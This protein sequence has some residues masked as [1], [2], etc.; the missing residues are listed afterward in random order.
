[1]QVPLSHCIFD[2]SRCLAGHWTSL[3]EQLDTGQAPHATCRRQEPRRQKQQ[4]RRQQRRQK[5]QRR[6]QRPLARPVGD[7]RPRVT[8]TASLQPPWPRPAAADTQQRPPRAD[9]S[10]CRRHRQPARSAAAA[11]LLTGPRRVHCRHLRCCRKGFGGGG[12]GGDRAGQVGRV[13]IAGGNQRAT[14]S[15]RPYDTSREGRLSTSQ[16]PRLVIGRVSKREN[17]K[18]GGTRPHLVSRTL[19]LALIDRTTTV[20]Y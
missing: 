18:R 15:A 13:V 11:R 16:P 6:R 1:M 19:F 5:Q 17:K 3:A 14:T 9:A 4:G 7:T 8:Q 20:N 2:K 12:G 10:T